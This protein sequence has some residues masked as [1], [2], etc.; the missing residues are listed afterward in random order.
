ME[1]KGSTVGVSFI[2]SVAFVF[3]Y[4]T[5]MQT[6]IQLNQ[7][8]ETIMGRLCCFIFMIM[9]LG[10]SESREADQASPSSETVD[11]TGKSERKRVLDTSLATTPSENS[12]SQ[13]TGLV[14]DVETGRSALQL[15]EWQ[16]AIQ[17]AQKHMSKFKGQ[18]SLARLKM[19]SA[20]SGEVIFVKIFKLKDLTPEYYGGGSSMQK[21]GNGKFI[22]VE[23]VLS[24]NRKKGHDP[25]HLSSSERGD[26]TVWLKVPENGKLNIVGDINIPSR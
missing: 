24:A 2:A 1:Q 25:L 4:D 23:H 17:T 3:T 21:I 14:N 20:Q 5:L 6:S 9:V 8:Q 16:K 19:N 15:P 11:P 7:V 10:C 18:Y 12:D 26:H 22:F 13:T